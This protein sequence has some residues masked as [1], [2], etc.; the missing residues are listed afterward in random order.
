M[1]AA[2]SAQR[3]YTHGYH[4]LNVHAGSPG[5]TAGLQSFFD[6]IV[7]ANG[8]ALD[9][10]D[11]RFV[12]LLMQSVNSTVQLIVYNSK[13][14]TFRETTI[15]PNM[16]WGGQG[17]LGVSIRFCK[18]KGINE[19][20][21]H[22]LDVYPNS[23]ASAA[24]L[25]AFTDYIVGSTGL[26]FGD[27]DAFYTLINVASGRDIELFVYNSESDDVRTVVLRPNPKWGG[28]GSVGCDVG[29]GILHRIP[30]KKGSDSSLPVAAPVQALAAS[31]GEMTF[32]PV[33]A[34]V[35][36]LPMPE[37]LPETVLQ[38][39]AAVPATATTDA[40]PLVPV[41]TATSAV[42]V[43][44]PVA[45]PVAAAI[46]TPSPAPA[47]QPEDFA[48]A[49][50]TPVRAVAAS[51][52]PKTPAFAPTPVAP[53]P[54]TPVTPYATSIASPAPDAGTV[55]PASTPVAA[56]TPLYA[57]PSAAVTP[58]TP[59]VPFTTSPGGGT[60]DFAA[61]RQKQAALKAKLAALQAGSQ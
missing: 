45:E 21:W 32:E 49:T 9:Q 5:A 59:T 22:V 12:D 53:G 17:V 4:V 47:S 19:N 34:P 18:L 2:E 6:V 39:A 48:T 29:F 15:Q 35:R 30:T 58:V 46:T 26:V 61:L 31:V 43:A 13:T 41:Q 16:Q 37:A 7:S 56:S 25:R 36:D 27:S 44:T 60:P 3:T 52:D 10:E 42:A 40:S 50:A 24:G 28:A 51:P 11:S 20:V 33:T 23:P 1:G 8:T 54:H 38:K 57:T 14:E 55:T